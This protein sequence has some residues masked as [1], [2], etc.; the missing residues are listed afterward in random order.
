[1]KPVLG[2]GTC[3]VMLVCWSC[4]IY[5]DCTTSECIKLNLLIQAGAAPGKQCAYI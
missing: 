5:G 4:I 1:M 3:Q 2:Y